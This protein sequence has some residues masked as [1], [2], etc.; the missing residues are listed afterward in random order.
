[1]IVLVQCVCDKTPVC[2]TIIYR[3]LHGVAARRRVNFAG[4]IV[5]LLMGGFLVLEGKAGG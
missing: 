1:M 4:R 5:V 3:S 2:R